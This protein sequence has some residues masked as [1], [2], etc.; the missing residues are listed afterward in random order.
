MNYSTRSG[1]APVDDGRTKEDG[2]FFWISFPVRGHYRFI[3]RQHVLNIILT[4][5]AI[6]LQCNEIQAREH[7]YLRPFLLPP[8]TPPHPA[9]TSEESDMDVHVQQTAHAR[10]G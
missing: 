7:T 10:E 2:R 6:T 8:L 3:S 4:P 9:L 1:A 5:M